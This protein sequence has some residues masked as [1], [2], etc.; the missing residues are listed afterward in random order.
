MNSNILAL[1]SLE[2]LLLAQGFLYCQ[3]TGQRI[4]SDEELA[5]ITIGND[6]GQILSL[7]V[8]KTYSK[9]LLQNEL[10]TFSLGLPSLE[11]LEEDEVLY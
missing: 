10:S 4:M 5:L 2:K 7:P 6:S 9:E 1:K 11:D 8:H 3:V